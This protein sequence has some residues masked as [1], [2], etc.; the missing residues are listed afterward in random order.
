MDLSIWAFWSQSKSIMFCFL[1]SAG[2]IEKESVN[3]LL[4]KVLCLPPSLSRP[5]ST[6]VHNKTGGIILFVLRFLTSLNDEGDLLFS[7]SNK[8]WM[9]DLNQ[10]QLKEIPGDV[11]THM[12]GKCFL[13]NKCSTLPKH[14][15]VNPSTWLLFSYDRGNFAFFMYYLTLTKITAFWWANTFQKH[16]PQDLSFNSSISFFSKWNI[17]L[18]KYG[19]GEPW[20]TSM[21][22]VYWIGFISIRLSFVL[23]TNEGWKLLPA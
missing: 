5:L 10:I 23:F 12:T 19:W 20:H 22:F 17:C 2:P 13:Y 21:L 7:M 1:C 6:V 4:S 16:Y 14:H 11:V 15:Q 9:Y 3:A 18:S 8:R